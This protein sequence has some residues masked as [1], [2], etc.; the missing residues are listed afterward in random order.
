MISAELCCDNCCIK[1]SVKGTP[2]VV[3]QEYQLL[4][5]VIL[6][7]LLASVSDTNDIN[8]TKVSLK[9]IEAYGITVSNIA[10]DYLNLV[11]KE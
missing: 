4:G 10:E 8:D 11:N 1:G 7:K 6:E 9:I 2:E 5:K 3:L